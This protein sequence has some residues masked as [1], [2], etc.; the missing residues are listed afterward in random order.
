MNELNNQRNIDKP[1]DEIDIFE[2]CSRVWMVFKNFLTG[3]KNFFIFIIILLIRKSLWI[4]SFAVA[5]IVFGFLLYGFSKTSYSSWLECNTGDLDNTIV[6]DH[7][8]RLNQLSGKPALLANFLNI[9]KEQAAKIGSIKA[10]Y[11]I[12]INKDDKYDFIDFGETYN[13]RDSNQMRVPSLMFI[14]VTV[15]DED[16]LPSLRNGLLHYI[17]NS[18]YLQ[19]L[20]KITRQQKE[21]MIVNIQTEIDKIDSLQ[22]SKFRKRENGD[23]KQMIYLSSETAPQTFHHEVL[24]LHSKKQTLEQELKISEEIIVI[25]HDFMPLSEEVFPLYKSV[26]ISSGIMAVLGL[27]CACIWQ[28]RKRIR[29]LITENSG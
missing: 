5:G 7:V 29:K 3:V 23:N 16:F 15:Y 19:E 12:D 22:R 1:N 17:K 8:N 24:E 27:L 26:F 21:Q 28:Y 10:Y 13:P 4:F 2:F 14:K 25:V 6:I 11:G 9:T 20:F 18:L